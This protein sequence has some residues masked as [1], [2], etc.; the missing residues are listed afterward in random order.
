M[1]N[2]LPWIVIVASIGLSTGAT[3]ADTPTWTTVELGQMDHVQVRLLVMDEATAGDLDWIGFEVE[4][5]GEGPMPPLVGR[6]QIDGERLDPKTGRFIAKGSI[7]RGSFD[8]DSPEPSLQRVAFRQASDYGTALLGRPEGGRVRVEA[9]VHLELRRH[10]GGQVLAPAEGGLKLE[11]PGLPFTFH[12]AAPGQAGLE[13]MRGRL[14]AMLGGP[15]PSTTDS[16]IVGEYLKWP[17]VASAVSAGELLDLLKDPDLGAQRS[18]FVRA[19]ADHYPEALVGH[20]H[21]QLRQGGHQVLSDL[22]VGSAV[23]TD[24]FIEPLVAL[25]ETDPMLGQMSPMTVLGHHREDWRDDET[26]QRR[27]VAGLLE[28]A[29]QLPPLTDQTPYADRR[30]WRHLFGQLGSAGHMDG[31][32]FALQYLDNPTWIR[33]RDELRFDPSPRVGPP[34]VRI[35]DL[36]HD[37]IARMLQLDPERTLRAFSEA[38]Y[39]FQSYPHAD[40]DRMLEDSFE[41]R[42]R[43]IAELRGLLEAAEGTQEPLSTP[44]EEGRK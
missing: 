33:T 43:L 36:A 16:Y 15:Y 41:V 4:N 7:G 37:A 19:L 27:L 18:M 31:L 1:L 11:W 39:D 38:G 25:H 34:V 24:A 42:D 6:F 20:L 14:I 35:R 23:W 22:V 21:S 10:Q 13:R 9:T 2:R 28:A 12:W 8:V 3:H 26:V 44:R 17:E 40:L 32:A 30:I 5:L 29:E